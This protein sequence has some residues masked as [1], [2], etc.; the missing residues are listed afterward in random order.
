MVI[1]CEHA[2]HKYSFILVDRR[3]VW[4]SR[5]KDKGRI[6]TIQKKQPDL[7]CG[8]FAVKRTSCDVLSLALFLL[9]FPIASAKTQ[10]HWFI[11]EVSPS[12]D[13]RRLAPGGLG[14]S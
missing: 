7:L 13:Y 12:Y 5:V 10:G 3:T 14:I 4:D 1:S 6:F 9:F 11:K 2:R 8:Y